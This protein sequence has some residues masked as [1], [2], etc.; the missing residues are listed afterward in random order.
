MGTIEL[1][2]DVEI[3]RNLYGGE[4]PQCPGFRASNQLRFEPFLLST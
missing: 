1:R 3:G 2:K 4:N